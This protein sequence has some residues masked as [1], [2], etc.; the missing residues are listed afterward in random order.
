MS[1]ASA[2][3]LAHQNCAQCGWPNSYLE[4]FCPGCGRRLFDLIVR[5]TVG[6]FYVDF[7]DPK[8][9]YSAQV[10]VSDGG[11][12][13]PEIVYA[14]G[15]AWIAY[16]PGG[17]LRLN[18]EGDQPMELPLGPSKIV[19]RAAPSDVTAEVE[20]CAYP[21]PELELKPLIVARG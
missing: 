3:P 16:D 17:F 2:V 20:V 13:G 6:T 1:A 21:V 11:W 5:P 19:F 7:A 12:G 9:S 4:M 14:S 8:P 15:P 18:G 10:Y